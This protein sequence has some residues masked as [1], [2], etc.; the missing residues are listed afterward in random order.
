MSGYALS[1]KAAADI[2]QIARASIKQW[3]LQ[4]A[5]AY[6]LGLHEAFQ[7]LAN[8]PDIG[9]DAG[10]IRAGYL[11]V[12]NG[13]HSIFYRKVEDGILIVRVMHGRMDFGRHL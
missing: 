10:E 7:R 11:R 6:V 12:E 9:H 8:F 2:A 1:G 4:R 13:S 5:E 3:G